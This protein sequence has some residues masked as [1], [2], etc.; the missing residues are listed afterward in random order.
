MYEQGP[1]IKAPVIGNER[2]GA[3]SEGERTFE[4]RGKSVRRGENRREAK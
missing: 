3:E 2:E 1:V 4:K